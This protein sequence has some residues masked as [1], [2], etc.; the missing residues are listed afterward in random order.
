VN[1]NSSVIKKEDRNMTGNI[2][3][4]AMLAITVLAFWVT[5]QFKFSAPIQAIIWISWFLVTLVLF[6]FT[7]QGKQSFIFAKESK[8]EMQKVVW[9]ARSETIQTTMIVMAMVGITGFVLWAIDM[10]M[11]WIIGKITHL[12]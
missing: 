8:V 4:I 6:Y 11:M 10:G 9:P 2:A 3:W 5:S 7:E 1:M 12:G